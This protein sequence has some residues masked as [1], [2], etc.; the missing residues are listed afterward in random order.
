MGAP[1]V[2]DCRVIGQVLYWRE[3]W[4]LKPECETLGVLSAIRKSRVT[5]Q[6]DGATTLGSPDLLI[7]RLYSLSPLESALPEGFRDEILPAHGFHAMIRL[8][9]KY[10]ITLKT[11]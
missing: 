11:L 9:V 1:V 3:G 7:T 5:T 2:P 6:R 8:C 4:F 10:I